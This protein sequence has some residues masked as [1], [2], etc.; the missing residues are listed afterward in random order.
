MEEPR[1]HSSMAFE[2]VKPVLKEMVA[3]CVARFKLNNRSGT[4]EAELHTYATIARGEAYNA[5]VE[6][7]RQGKKDGARELR[8]QLGLPIPDDDTPTAKIQIQR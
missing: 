2:A 1:S 3:K 8:E 4:P 7:Y 5:V 6:S